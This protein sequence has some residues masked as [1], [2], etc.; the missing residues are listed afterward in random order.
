[1]LIDR[2]FGAALR[3]AAHIKGAW[4][5]AAPLQYDVPTAPSGASAVE[6]AKS[7]QVTPDAAL[8]TWAVAASATLIRLARGAKNTQ[9]A[10][11]ARRSLEWVAAEARGDQRAADRLREALERD[12]NL[13]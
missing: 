2:R 8:L 10:E 11:Y 5:L 3:Q 7:T 6:A 4:P 9:A 13:L 1:M 12:Y